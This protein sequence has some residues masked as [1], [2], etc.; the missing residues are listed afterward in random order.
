[1]QVDTTGIARDESVSAP[2][3]ILPAW[4]VS[5][6]ILKKTFSV[7]T[8]QAE[9]SGQVINPFNWPR[10][11]SPLYIRAGMVSERYDEIL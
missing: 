2:L 5:A 8:W 11:L 10:L 9:P 7:A 4:T 6:G 1:M 3:P